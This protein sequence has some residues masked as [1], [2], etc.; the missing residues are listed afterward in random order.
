MFKDEL[1]KTIAKAT[2]STNVDV[3]R[4]LDAFMETVIKTVKKGDE[5][6][7]IGF[8]TFKTH[9][10]AARTGRNPRTG[11][12]MKIP[13]KRVAKFVPGSKLKS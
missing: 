13:A 9:V 1:I 12:T 2:K 10:R 5:I 6:R 3:E 7:L 8:G 4:V 11:G